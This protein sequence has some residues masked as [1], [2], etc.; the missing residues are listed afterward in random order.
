MSIPFG[1]TSEPSSSDDIAEPFDPEEFDWDVP[2]GEHYEP[3]ESDEGY[4]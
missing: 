1:F 4:A 3:S 2:L